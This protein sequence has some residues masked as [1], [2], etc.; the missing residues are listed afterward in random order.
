MLPP[1]AEK[2]L[3]SWIRSRHL[4]CDGNFFIFDTIDY[5]CI[6][7]FHTC[8]SAL[9]GSLIS[10]DT[11]DKIWMGD[12]R[13]VFLYRAK[14]SLNVPCNQVRQYWFKYGGLYTRFDKRC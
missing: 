7:R 10:V 1:E 2:K 8:I 13:Q 11:I 4:I 12:H 5:S 6:E 3:K 9:G 14:A